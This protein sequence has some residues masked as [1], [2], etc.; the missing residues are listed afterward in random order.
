M[1]KIIDTLADGFNDQL[2]KFS[3]PV[4]RAGHAAERAYKMDKAGTPHSA[5]A[6]ILTDSSK[7][8]G[9]KHTYRPSGIST[10]VN[11]YDDA[12]VGTPISAKTARGV[13]ADQVATHGLDTDPL[14]S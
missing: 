3:G 5:I 2:E 7:R 10:L 9:K 1:T 12:L 14:I 13:I 8:L 11:L 4:D 6:A